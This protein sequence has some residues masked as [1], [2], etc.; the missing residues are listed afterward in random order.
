MSLQLTQAKIVGGIGALLSLVGFIFS[1]VL[2]VVGMV[3]TLLAVKS[4]SEY[5]GDEEAF[6]SYL[7]SVI[8]RIVAAAVAAILLPV[9]GLSAVLTKGNLIAVMATVLPVIVLLW[10]LSVVA[11]YFIKRSYRVLALRLDAGPFATAG[12]LYFIGSFLLIVAIGAIVI[13]IAGVFEV[14]AYFSIPRKSEK[15]I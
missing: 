12:I 6:R 13:L 4:L 1:R 9:A 10:V 2:A 8:L 5:I 11:A 15:H 7:I 3:L 14:L